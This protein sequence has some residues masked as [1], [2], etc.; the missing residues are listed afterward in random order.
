MPDPPS[1]KLYDP[2][3]YMCL[4]GEVY[5]PCGAEECGSYC[6]PVAPCECAEHDD[7]TR[8]ESNQ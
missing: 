6:E 8:R 1:C 4:N 3:M 5:G 2:D 7:K